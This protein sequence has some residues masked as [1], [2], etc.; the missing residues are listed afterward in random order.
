MQDLKQR[1][2]RFSELATRV[3]PELNRLLAEGDELVAIFVAS[4]RR[5]RQ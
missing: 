2:K 3:H 4:K 5:A 1:T